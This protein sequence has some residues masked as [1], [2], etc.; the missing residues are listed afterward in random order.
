VEVSIF[1]RHVVGL[2]YFKE[3][4]STEN[5]DNPVCIESLHFCEGIEAGE[6]VA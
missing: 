4:I 6:L 2:L 3:G 5:N 1:V